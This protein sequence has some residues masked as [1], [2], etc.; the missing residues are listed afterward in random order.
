[1][2]LK[3]LHLETIDRRMARDAHAVIAMQKLRMNSGSVKWI[4]GRK[5]LDGDPLSPSPLLMRCSDLE[6][7]SP[8]QSEVEAELLAT[9]AGELVIS[10]EREQPEM[11]P[12][13]SLGEFG[14]GI[15]IPQ[16]SKFPMKPLQQLSVTGF[17]DF[18]AC[19][20]RFWLK[21][22]LKLQVAEE[23]RSELDAKLFGSYIHIVLQRFGDDESVKHSSNI[24]V[25]EKSV[26]DA[27]D[28][29]V[30]DQLG[31]NKSSKINI[32]LELA[33]FRL[34]EF[35]KHQAESV[36][37]GWTIV[38][39]ERFVEKII[40]INEQQFTIRGV[41]DRVE[42]NSDGRIRILDYKTGSTTANKAHFM[43]D[44]WI[45]LQLP[46]YRKLIT[47]ISELDDCDLSDDNILLG[48]F[49]IGDQETTSGID[50]L[51]PPEK[52]A[53]SLEYTISETIQS[54]LKNEYSDSPAI[55]SPK[56]SDNYSWICQ[57][58]SIVEETSEF[59]G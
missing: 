22:V 35:A 36:N 57:D 9:R 17:R 47:E 14:D 12:Q 55:P 15:G 11:P 1:M 19:S 53:S 56:F 27:L 50:L 8:E 52:I 54:I 7:L 16:P 46:L 21:H 45:D 3:A 38:C 5:N 44:R 4:V 29:V 32:Q 28:R 20:Y 34:K 49:R 48:Y 40:E 39:T 30:L 26:F 42:I 37:R 13:F 10:F 23:G 51:S 18:L 2:L 6:T 58:N 43:K 33:R 59:Y 31:P 24:K 25:I 41:I